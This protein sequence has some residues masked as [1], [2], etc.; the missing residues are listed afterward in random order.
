M[1]LF[2]RSKFECKG[3]VSG[4]LALSKKVKIYDVSKQ[5][6]TITFWCHLK[7]EQKCIAILT[8]MCYNFAVKNRRGFLPF[9]KKAIS[10]TGILAG[11]AIAII[12][13]AIYP[14][15]VLDVKVN[16]SEYE[17]AVLEVLSASGVKKYSFAFKVD[18]NDIE[19]KLLSLD[20][21][22]FAKVT[23]CGTLINVSLEKELPKAEIFTVSNEPVVAKKRAVFSRAVVFSGICVKKYGD[24]VD[25]GDALIEGY[26]IVGEEKVPCAAEGIVFGKVYYEAEL[27]YNH[28]GGYKIEDCKKTVKML[29][30]SKIDKDASILSESY[31]VYDVDGGFNVKVLIETEERIDLVK[32]ETTKQTIR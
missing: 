7:D 15:F 6:E 25:I 2:D 18:T 5:G 16:E 30:V 4:I 21:V 9:F 23:R 24:V 26:L 28:T 27:F 14:L 29:A 10:R 20:G 32:T 31:E 13:T 19:K 17:S 12:V 8:D 11:L 3:S 1:R 22:S